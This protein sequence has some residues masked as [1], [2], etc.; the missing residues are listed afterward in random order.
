MGRRFKGKVVRG[1]RTLGG[2]RTGESSGPRDLVVYL[3]RGLVD[4]P[5]A[6][7]VNEI[8]RTDAT[9]LELRV[10]PGDLGKVIGKSGRTAQAMRTLL[11][12]GNPETDRRVVLDI[13]D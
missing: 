5:E 4:D 6:V 10:A 7:A 1:R 3:A 8:Q 13:I 2:H 11:G 12:I 9:V